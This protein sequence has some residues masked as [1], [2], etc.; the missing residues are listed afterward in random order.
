MLIVGPFSLREWIYFKTPF[1]NLSFFDNSGCN[2]RSE[3]KNQYEF[4]GRTEEVGTEASFL[5][6]GIMNYLDFAYGIIWF[7]PLVFLCGLFTLTKNIKVEHILFAI[8]FISFI[9]VFYMIYAG[10]AEDFARYTI[11]LLPP[12]ALISGNYFKELYQFLKKYLKQISLLV[13]IPVIILSF[14]N[15]NGKLYVARH[16]D[17]GSGRYVGYKMFSPLFFDACDWIKK[18]VDEDARLGAV[19]W[20]SATLYNCQRNTGGGGGDIVLSNNVTLALSSIKAQGITHIFI[21]KF[22]IDWADSKLSE[23]YPI[24][25]VEFLENNPEHFKKV[26][27][28]GPS[29]QQCRQMGGCDGAIVY[30][31]NY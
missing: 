23:R 3:Y 10:R 6:M 24:S 12:I 20:V 7:V 8:L 27:E 18:N 28:N 11:A 26:Y 1:C 15:L 30:E 2:I 4:A 17:E 16:Y 25:F 31:V 21:Q 5:K 13:F 9:P 14:I 29:L 19:I 22:S